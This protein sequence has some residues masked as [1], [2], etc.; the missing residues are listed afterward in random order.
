VIFV[1]LD[2]PDKRKNLNTLMHHIQNVSMSQQTL[3]HS[4]V[5][6]PISTGVFHLNLHILL[7]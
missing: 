4:L 6:W 1:L 3:H 7:I 5:H 2:I